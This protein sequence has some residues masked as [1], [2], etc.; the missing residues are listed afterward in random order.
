MI[1]D[2]ND[3]VDKS[4]LVDGTD[5]N[6]TG[7]DAAK[8]TDNGHLNAH[9][10][11]KTMLQVLAARGLSDLKRRDQ[12]FATL[13]HWAM[14][15]HADASSH[16]RRIIEIPD[17]PTLAGIFIEAQ[18]HLNAPDLYRATQKSIEARGEWDITTRTLTREIYD[19]DSPLG[20]A[21]ALA[22]IIVESNNYT[23]TD[24]GNARRF[25]DR[26]SHRVRYV[27]KW[28]RWL[29]NDGIRWA[30]PLRG[31]IE[32]WACEV[33][34]E[35][36]RE[37]IVCSDLERRKTLTGH[38]AKSQSAK[39]ER[40]LIIKASTKKG[41]AAAPEDFDGD[42]WALN[43]ASG[44]IDLKSGALRPHDSS[45]HITK[46]APSAY[47]L[48][49]ACPNWQKFL[50]DICAD[51][52]QT[53]GFIRRALGYAI[54]GDC[55]ENALL[56]FYGSGANGKST[57]LD[58][59]SH[60]L[61]DYALRIEAKTLLARDS[62]RISNDIAR[63]RGA[64]FVMASE[65]GNGRRLDEEK[66]KALT[67]DSRLTGEF[68]YGEAFDFDRTF[69]LFLATN[70]RPEIKGT[71]DGIWRRV[72]L[73]PFA[74]RFWN[75][76]KGE[77]GP[78]PLRQ[79]KG[80][81]EKLKAERAAILAWLVQGC[82]EWQSEGLN[83][84]PKVLAATAEYR[85]E[86]DVIGRFLSERCILGATYSVQAGPIYEAFSS[87]CKTNGEKE[88]TAKDFGIAL[89]ERDGINPKKTNKSNIYVG[90]GLL[91]G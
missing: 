39:A 21:D 49:A 51:D 91:E 44:T 2:K 56:I 23:L 59:V 12:A 7:R 18:S 1:L 53:I 40:D 85:A 86:S 60:I 36:L 3:A 80:L 70:H 34:D 5:G 9:A 31:E 41:V 88:I 26:N 67:G 68:K 27:P 66:V 83:A 46:L 45:D 54:T 38:A 6:K 84:P 87:W 37:V 47:E 13:L 74:V 42:L 78:A 28:K 29:I 61:G 89:K 90:F 62:D 19:F 55:R 75:P 17:D 65:T 25:I 64:R 33:A 22:L 79:D 14:K 48:Q 43:C 20:I 58:I 72:Y 77:T 81:L 71:D 57:L 82:I 35:M 52:A 16:L 32:Q 8:A 15:G 69:T 50:C 30:E 76:D 11:E 63:L 4:R 10:D 24:E 73:V